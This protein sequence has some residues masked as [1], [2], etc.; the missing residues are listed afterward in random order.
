MFK[1]ILTALILSISTISAYAQESK[2]VISVQIREN[3]DDHLG[4]IDALLGNNATSGVIVKQLIT[5]TNP[6]PEKIKE[7]R[8]TIKQTKPSAILASNTI[9]ATTA[10]GK[11][12]VDSD[13]DI[14]KIPVVLSSVTNPKISGLV[15]DNS[16]I[17]GTIHVPKPEDV[18]SL[19]QRSLVKRIS[20]AAIL[21]T[22]NELPAQYWAKNL[23][24]V[25]E[26]YKIITK[27]V[28]VKQSDTSI[29]EAINS[30]K[31]VDIIIIGPDTFLASNNPKKIST[32]AE[33]NNIPVLAVTSRPITIANITLTLAANG[34]SVG[35]DAGEKVVRILNGE[36]AS[37]IGIDT[38]KQITL[39][40][41]EEMLNKFNIKLNDKALETAQTITIS[42]D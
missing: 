16:N 33:N 19:L 20:T 29:E 7:I 41:R 27:L 26:R 36:T 34:K 3:T 5:G 10:I 24:D 12:G 39:Q 2:T 8:D 25:S 18:L 40:Y 35:L 30:I 31:G 21:V 23:V 13:E 28:N 42:V 9:A 15:N 14:R 6:T 11:L 32:I 1:Y 17:A 4:L 38:I 22:E 37:N